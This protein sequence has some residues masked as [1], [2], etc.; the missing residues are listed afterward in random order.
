MPDLLTHALIGYLLGTALSFRYE[1][2][3]T[4]YVTVC[5]MG[6]FIPDLTKIYLVVSSSHVESWFG[7]PFDWFALH[8]VGGSIVSVAVGTV[9]VPRSY[10]RRVFGLLV[11]GASSHLL[12]DALLFTPSGYMSPMLWPVIDSHPAVPGFYLSSDRRPAVIA[13]V[14]AAVVWV[15]RRRYPCRRPDTGR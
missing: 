11:L 4:P 7:L 13:A 10:R 12:F 6:A 14:L 2:V 3:T 8:T 5:M 15:A 1:W 9:L